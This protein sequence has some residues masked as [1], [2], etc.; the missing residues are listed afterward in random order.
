ML[1][2][3]LSGLLS[4]KLNDCS[5]AKNKNEIFL[6]L[7]IFV[8]F[9]KNA[10]SQP[11]TKNNSTAT[12]SVYISKLSSRFTFISPEGVP[13][14]AIGIAHANLPSQS[15]RL[16]SDAT[17][18]LFKDSQE[19]FNNDRDAWL[20]NA[21]FNTFSY[22]TPGKKDNQFYWVETLNLFPGF[23][24]KGG[25]CPDLFSDSFRTAGLE[26]I[27]KIVPSI[28][29]DKYLLGISLGLPV[30]AS[31]H[32]MPT[33]SWQRRNERPI[34]YLYNLQSLGEKSK[35]KVK[36]IAHLEERFGDVKSYCRK[37]N[38][39]SVN[40]WGELV[41]VDLSA[42]ENPFH[43][44][45][46][47]A[48]FYQ[49]MWGEIIELFAKEVKSLA[50]QKIVFA[51][52]LIG[53]AN[54]PDSWLDV[55]FKAVGP[56]VDAFIP[57]LYGDNDYEGILNR[58]GTLTQKPS[59]IGDGMRPREF[60]YADNTNDEIEAIVYESMFTSLSKN[61]WFLGSTICEYHTQLPAYQWYAER[62]NEARLGIRNIDYS[63][64]RVLLEIYK[65]L[66][67]N[68]RLNK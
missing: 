40:R 47:D 4:Y 41:G 17:S 34:N 14:V 36:Y 2:Y 38:W 60:N 24:N 28:K 6:L 20:R 12:G 27:R 64:R 62:I 48:D 63:N 51:P 49:L 21:G 30:L 65:R 23:I 44:H 5:F 8:C 7:L 42:F 45:P 55:W 35:G 52:R 31:P 32:Q 13:F 10:I 25:Q 3:L 56:Y 46:D 18:R 29:N 53:L 1:K 22:T 58:I 54:F 37:R 67:F 39:K 11:L 15:R 26:Q 66:H 43:L 9:F 61:R 68:N 57:E 50:P 19:L 16:P 33:R 59:F